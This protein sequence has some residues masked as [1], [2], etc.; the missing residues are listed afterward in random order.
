[1]QR[2]SGVRSSPSRLF[3]YRECFGKPLPPD[4]IRG[5]AF[6][7]SDLEV[8]GRGLAAVGDFLVFHRLPLIERRKPGPLDRRNMNEHVLSASRRLDESKTLGRV[9]PLHGTFSHH[10]VSAGLKQSRSVGPWKPACPTAPRY[11]LCAALDSSNNGPVSAEI[12]GVCRP[13]RH[14]LRFWRASGACRGID[15]IEMRANGFGGPHWV[16]AGVAS[17]C[18]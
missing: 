8:L 4:P 13:D 2:E 14:F 16:G 1:M 17:R 7:L 9:K 5:R 18:Q 15:F 10:V 11:A 3:S 6:E 12:E